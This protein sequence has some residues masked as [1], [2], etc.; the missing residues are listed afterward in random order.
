MTK[1]L[2]A[3]VAIVIIGGG[4]LFFYSQKNAGEVMPKDSM[5]TDKDGAT[6]D[7]VDM[8]KDKAMMD[9]DTA[10]KTGDTMM[11]KDSGMTSETGTYETYAPEKLTKANGGHVVLFFRASWCPTCRALDADIKAHLKDIPK[12]VTILD[13]DYDTSTVLKQKYGVTHQHTLVQVDASGKQLATWSGS[14]T[15]AEFLT[16]VK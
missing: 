7:A 12:G 8:A 9:T 10:S 1:M 13:V 15:L 3:I 11:N 4:G 6:P 16:H 14:P 5:M 2:V